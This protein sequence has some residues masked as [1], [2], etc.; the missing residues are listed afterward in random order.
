MLD[1]IVEQTGRCFEV[2]ADRLIAVD[3]LLMQR[4]WQLKAESDLSQKA[5]YRVIKWIDA[6]LWICKARCSSPY[7]E[8][9]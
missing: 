4:G 7:R 8:F 2:L 9:V 6:V 5:I 1:L 3:G